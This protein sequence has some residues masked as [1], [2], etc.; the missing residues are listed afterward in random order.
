M[1]A[2]CRVRGEQSSPAQLLSSIRSNAFG[3][4][5]QYPV[6]RYLLRIAD[7]LGRSVPLSCSVS[8]DGKACGNVVCASLVGLVHRA[9]HTASAC[10]TSVLSLPSAAPE[11]SAVGPSCICVPY[12][13]QEPKQ[14]Q[15]LF[16]QNFD[17]LLSIFNPEGFLDITFL[18]AVH[19][20]GR[21]DKGNV[22]LLERM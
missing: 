6:Q 3:I 20:V 11:P 7:W 5:S 10:P 18:D 8:N 19:R 21:D 2:H 15:A 1:P 4:G 14:L 12:I 16:E 22:F 13:S 17:L 9:V